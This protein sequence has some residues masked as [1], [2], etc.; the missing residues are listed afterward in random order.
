M[1]YYH[2]DRDDFYVNVL[3]PEYEK[4]LP[5][6][7]IRKR[8]LYVTSAKLECGEKPLNELDDVTMFISDRYLENFNYPI[9]V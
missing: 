4:I 1:P 6:S 3:R 8:E 5:G 9:L 7:I 2:Y